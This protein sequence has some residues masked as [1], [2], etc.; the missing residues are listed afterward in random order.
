MRTGSAF[1]LGFALS[2]VVYICLCVI[3]PTSNSF[4]DFAAGFG[5][6]I[7]HEGAGVMA[8]MFGFI[9]P[10]LAFFGVPVINWAAKEAV[11]NAREREKAEYERLQEEKK[12]KLEQ[13][14]EK[15]RERQE[16]ERREELE[17]AASKYLDN[18]LA[19]K[20][21]REVASRMAQKIESASRSASCKSYEEE[22]YVV[23]CVTCADS[24][25]F[26]GKSVLFDGKEE[27]VFFSDPRSFALS[28]CFI[29]LNLLQKKYL[30]DPS[31][32]EIVHLGFP[33][34]FISG[35]NF[36]YP[37]VQG[38]KRCLI[39]YKAKNS[40]FVKPTVI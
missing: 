38:A 14:R 31:G 27:R 29:A 23:G 26:F 1:G 30:V 17:Q 35:A 8:V 20:L 25:I 13:W 22:I 11:A 18:P 4:I 39:E 9:F 2:V 21:G 33:D 15:E 36:D 19:L 7:D 12:R 37:V 3:F 32:G 16:R 10:A 28:I 5:L 6:S 24:A 34:G 40:R